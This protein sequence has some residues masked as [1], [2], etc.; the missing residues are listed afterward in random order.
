MKV[1]SALETFNR[2]A[3]DLSG[4]TVGHLW[5]GHGSAIFLEFGELRAPRDPDGS[6][7]RR[8]DGSLLNPQGEITVGIEWNWRIETA[9]SI[10]CGSGC[11][12]ERLEPGLDLLRASYVQGLSLV[13]RLPEIDLAFTNG[14]HLVT[15]MTAEG[16]P[17]WSLTDRRTSP[18]TW[19]TVR[20]G[21]LFESDGTVPDD[22]PPAIVYAFSKK[23]SE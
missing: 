17:D 15:F 4:L 23:R 14:L 8:R 16:Q 5:R 11:E 9:T 10:L 13:G 12:D 6:L 21:A 3:A 1:M 22:P 2:L 7:S 18:Q 19:V 20:R